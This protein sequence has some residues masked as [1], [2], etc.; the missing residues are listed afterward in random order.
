MRY[1]ALSWL[2]IAHAWLPSAGELLNGVCKRRT[3]Y[4]R[5]A[6]VDG[7]MWIEKNS[8]NQEKTHQFSF[9]ILCVKVLP[10]LNPD[11]K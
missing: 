10:Y 5:M 1:H 11:N 3:G 8:D 2:K 7:K 9:I 4:L 6:D